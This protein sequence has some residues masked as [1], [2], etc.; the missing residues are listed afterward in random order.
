MMYNIYMSRNQ[1]RDI[2]LV[3]RKRYMIRRVKESYALYQDK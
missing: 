1:P 2:R 3:E